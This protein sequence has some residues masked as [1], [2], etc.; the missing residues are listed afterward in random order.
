M[1]RFLHIENSIWDFLKREA[2]VARTANWT[3]LLLMAVF[4]VGLSSSGALATTFN[5]VTDFS[6][7]TNTASN[8]WSY[9]FNTSTDVSTYNSGLALNSVLFDTTCGFGTSCWDQSSGEQ[10]LI[11]QN[12]TGADAPFP[13][14]IGRNDQ[15]TFYTRSGLELVRFTA[16]SAG[17]YT[18]SGFFEGNAVSPE[19]TTEAIAIDGALISDSIATVPF[20]AINPFSFTEALA[21]SDT[22]DFLVAGI[23]TTGDANSLATG[24]D[25]TIA[26]ATVTVPEPATIFL[27][28][29]ALVGFGLARRRRSS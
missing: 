24:F 14:G 3:S 12:V 11:L 29:S 10:N 26:P 25:A 22:V 5:A 19:Q 2:S 17:S 23:S 8:T 13:N 20:G 6:L 27:L 21:A 28:G 15:L 16:P 7:S 4:A 1:A 18:I 9:W